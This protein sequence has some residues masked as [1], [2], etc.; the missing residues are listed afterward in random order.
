MLY[1]NYRGNGHGQSSLAQE[2]LKKTFVQMSLPKVEAENTDVKMNCPLSSWN[3]HFRTR[4]NPTLSL[5]L[6]FDL[7][8]FLSNLQSS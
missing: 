3:L 4:Q 5:L 7:D 8:F 6:L 1:Y 2:L